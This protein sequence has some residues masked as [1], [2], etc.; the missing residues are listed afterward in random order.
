ML[1]FLTATLVYFRQKHQAHKDLEEKNQA[2]NLDLFS[3]KILQ[4]LSSPYFRC[5]FPQTSIS[6][7]R[8]RSDTR[9]STDK[10]HDALDIRRVFIIS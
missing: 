2:Q 1:I 8:Q 4:H 7:S 10:A 3:F 5:D 6:F 9:F